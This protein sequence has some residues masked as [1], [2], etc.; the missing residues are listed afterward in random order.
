M[1]DSKTMDVSQ[2]RFTSTTFPSA[3]D[4]TLWNSLSADEQRAVVRRDLDAA[5]AGGVAEVETAGAI[6]RRVRA[7]TGRGS[8]DATDDP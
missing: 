7:E 2:I 4:M 8:P 5:E 1:A 6:I 3:E